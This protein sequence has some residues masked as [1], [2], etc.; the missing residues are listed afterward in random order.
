VLHNV[1]D[2]EDA[3][4]A[5]F[6]VLAKKAATLRQPPLLSGWLHGVAYHVAL[7]LKA[8][9][10]RRTAHEH[11]IDPLPPGDAMDD[12]T[13]RELRSVLDEELQRLPEKYRAP[14]VLC[15]LEARTQDEAA[16]HLGWSKNTFGRRINQARQMLARRLT[17]R[18]LT[19]PAALT[20]PL[21]IDGT[22]SA[23]LPP[24]L[25]A[26]TVRAGLVLAVGNPAS[27]IVSVQVVAL[28]ESGV[29]SLLTKKS[30]IALVLLASLALGVGGLLA[31]RV[32]H[33]RTFA[34]ARVVPPAPAT[35]SAPARSASKD[36]DLEIKGRVLDPDGKPLAGARLLLRSGDAAQK[37]GTSVRATTDKDGLFRFK[38]TAADFGPQ[39]KTTLAAATQGFGPDW[40]EITA[41]HRNDLTL[42]LVK[43]DKPIEGRVLD[44][45]GK[46]I[47]GVTLEVQRL[48]RKAKDEDL[49]SW[50]DQHA[51]PGGYL[52]WENG[53]QSVHADLLDVPVT[54][55]TNADGKVRLSGFGRER[56]LRLKL[57][58]PA[59][60]HRTFWAMTR[61]GPTKGLK[62]GDYGFYAAAFDMV[63][64]PTKPIIGTVRDRTTGKPLAQ[65]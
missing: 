48:A 3:F 39:G 4:Q 5:T 13:W 34:E 31:Q 53:L 59:I 12:I 58:G 43:D 47:A 26:S 38:A 35:P 54:A 63:V 10:Q 32:L 21:L 52:A 30:S 17:R 62:P 45:E 61:Q 40:I 25:V 42:R 51:K 60:E 14:L 7:R 1:Q 11:R 37:A 49:T 28:A 8:K 24:L 33:S 36:Q 41:E 19:L 20:A 56:V 46:P 15:Y 16:R 2:V 55:T 23:A 44:L 57:H 22:A 6:L 9:T 64:G 29:G 18:G 27:G 50:L 65:W